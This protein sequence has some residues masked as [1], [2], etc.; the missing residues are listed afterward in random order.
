MT[1]DDRNEV[2]QAVFGYS[3]GHRM[4]ASS[5]QLSSIDNYELAAASD[6][7]PG[8]SL[9]PS[10]SYLTGVSL[11]DSK[12]YAFIKTWAAPEMHRPGC[13][14]S[15]VLLL[16]RP[17]LSSQIDLAVLPP[18]FRRPSGYQSDHAFSKPLLV[19]RKER[20]ASPSATLVEQALLACYDSVLLDGSREIRSEMERAILAVWSQQWPRMRSAFV[21]R[22]IQSSSLL[23][24]QAIRLRSDSGG[25]ATAFNAK[26]WL[27][28]ATDDA[29]AEAVTPLRRFLWRYGKDIDP[30]Q[31]PFVDLVEIFMLLEGKRPSY[32]DAAQILAKFRAGQAQTLKRDILGVASAKAA[33]VKSVDAADLIR[34]MVEYDFSEFEV[35]ENDLGG[36]FQD[37][38]LLA[39]PGVAKALDEFQD[40]LG[41]RHGVIFDAILPSFTRDILESSAIPS[42]LALE[43]IRRRHDL[44]SFQALE[45][46]SDVEL[47]ALL[48]LDLSKTETREVLRAMMSRPPVDGAT[49]VV[50]HFPEI[51]L[52]V[53]V[54][55][56]R[57][58]GLMGEWR[59]LLNENAERLVPLVL[60][61]RDD[62][63][64]LDAA[65]AMN[66]P[67]NPAEAPKTWMSAFRKYRD[68]LDRASE[69]SLMTF[70][71]VLCIRHQ[72]ENTRQIAME[73]MPDLRWRIVSGALSPEDEKMLG[74][75]LPNVSDSWDL[76]KRLLKLLRQGY[77]RGA[78]YDDL[79]WPLGL[80]EEEYAYATNQDPDNLARQVARMFMPWGRWD[81]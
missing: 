78:N 46:F 49:I 5:I 16:S 47:A 28:V 41:D 7:A 26:P 4:L 79:V 20:A 55:Q 6:L 40:G 58:G 45:R 15:H 1:N 22:S 23:P 53:A 54:A 66:F 73:I 9:D 59:S 43:A 51:C 76:N 34:L 25:R 32:D 48:D 21:F 67:L 50:E 30:T 17:L 57:R 60:E 19:G 35:R 68:R 36:L 52:D 69:T 75:W 44:I 62:G 13:V 56:Q 3:N 65:R 8:V 39:L 18:L 77:K 74:R 31:Q 27:H 14:W 12:L 11:P 81:D 63:S 71:M 10:A 80:S 29:V 2:H 42:G 24:S 33:L 70:I 64:V 61:L 38:D 72:L 37:I